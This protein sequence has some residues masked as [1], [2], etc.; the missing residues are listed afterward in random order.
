MSKFFG[1]KLGIDLGTANSVVFVEGEGI[2]LTEPT[3]VALDLE[4]S[5]ILAVGD[6][7]KDML[8]K[9]PDNIVAKRP[10]RN[11]VIADSRITESLL[12]Y[13]FNKALGSNR[14]FKP[15]VIISVPA[16]INSV[17]RRAVIKAAMSAGAR[18][19]HL[20]P[21]PL[22]AAIGAGIPIYKSSGNMIVN[23]GGGTTEIGVVSLN[24]LVKSSSLRISGDAMNEA[25]VNY[26]RR[27]HSFSIGEQTAE[28]VKIEIG[29]CIKVNEPSSMQVKGRD[30]VSGMPKSIDIDSNEVASALQ[31]PLNQ[32]IDEIH[33]VL[34]RTPPE[35]SSDIIDK[36]IVLSGGT[37]LITNIDKLFAKATG[38]PVY[39]ADEPMYC[40]ANGTGSVLEMMA[41]GD[42][43]FAS[44]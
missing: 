30:S 6:E 35:I 10:L 26:M 28:R 21:E 25:I 43:S 1:K 23:M 5:S 12:K 7:A 9:T 34:E 36:G 32:I 38:V 13:F 18:K 24:G 37:A 17:E 42:F 14:F 29:S 3:V 41:G 11:G 44:W 27:K 22:L 40:V 4:K 2:V 31:N 16:G 8:G 20:M 33:S 39:L 19:I 15:N